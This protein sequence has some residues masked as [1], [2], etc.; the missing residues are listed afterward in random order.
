M[1]SLSEKLLLLELTI[2]KFVDSGV[3]CL[4]EHGEAE[5]SNS[6]R[7][8]R[9]LIGT[10]GTSGKSS[11]LMNPRSC[12]NPSFLLPDRLDHPMSSCTAHRRNDKYEALKTNLSLGVSEQSGKV[13]EEFLAH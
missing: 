3:D 4:E 5:S 9:A 8:A 13:S 2:S 11:P 1:L 6:G 10:S 7:E 12:K